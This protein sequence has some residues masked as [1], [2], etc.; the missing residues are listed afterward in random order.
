MK[1]ENRKEEKEKNGRKEDERKREREALFI[2]AG[3]FVGIV[4]II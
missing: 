2:L 3:Q 4:R 1:K